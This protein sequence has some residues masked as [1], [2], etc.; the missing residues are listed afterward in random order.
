METNRKA[1]IIIEGLSKYYGEFAALKNL[2]LT[3][4][5]G[6]VTG[7]LGPNGAGKTTLVETI[8]GLRAPTTGSISV[9]G[10]HPMDNGY[11]LKE[12][13]GVQL[14]ET[15]LPED[16]TV[17]ETLRLFGSF[18]QKKQTPDALIDFIGLKDKRNARTRTL[19]GG[20]KQKLSIAVALIHDPELVVFDEP[21][22]GLDP[23]ARRSIHQLI[24]RLKQ[25]GK[26]ILLTTHYLEEAEKLCD[27]VLI[28]KAGQF[29]ADGSPNALIAKF[30]DT[31]S[32]QIAIHGD[33]DPHV[34]LPA[35]LRDIL[36]FQLKKQ[37]YFHFTTKQ[38]TVA[39]FGFLAAIKEQG[40]EISD[41]HLNKP[42]LE[43]IYLGLIQDPSKEEHDHVSI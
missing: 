33:F 39:L 11:Q 22:T 40:M 26:S 41:L 5:P 15:K 6:Q 36:V 25:E 10:L 7:I 38:P 35:E 28:L 21:T 24:E 13:I 14:Q 30:A 18:Y 34:N 42:S 12:R 1:V 16:L 23:S 9:L 2:D 20:Q 32:L 43:D 37:G 17:F 3:L 29:V 19:S 8:E 4:L 27:R 31:S